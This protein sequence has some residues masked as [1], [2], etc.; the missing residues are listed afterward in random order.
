MGIKPSVTLCIFIGKGLLV[1]QV[2]SALVDSA[3]LMLFDAVVGDV[4]L[5]VVVEM[6]VGGAVVVVEV[7]VVDTVV[8]AVVVDLQGAEDGVADFVQVVNLL[9]PLI[10]LVEPE[11]TIGHMVLF[12]FW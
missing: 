7:M 8:D 2:D 1:C 6:V 3:D 10:G 4:S 12:K 9:K 11:L 5:E